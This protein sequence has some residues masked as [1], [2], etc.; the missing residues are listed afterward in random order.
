MATRGQLIVA[1]RSRFGELGVW[2][3]SSLLF[4]LLH[5]PNT[6]FGTGVFGLLQVPLSFLAG[7]VFY[8][9]RRASGT[10]IFAM[11]LHALWDF[12]TFAADSSI[13]SFPLVGI[14]ALVVVV[15]LTRRE[16][17]DAHTATRDQRR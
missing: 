6:L 1:L 3:F 12:S 7:T 16:S 8:L 10:L 17:R 4:G 15:R 13:N 14:V 9:L 11:A 5:L 2:F